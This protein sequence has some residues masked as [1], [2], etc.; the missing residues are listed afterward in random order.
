MGYFKKLEAEI[1][2][3]P[4]G[5]TY[6]HGQGFRAA[7]FGLIPLIGD[8]AYNLIDARMGTVTGV[9]VGPAEELCINIK[10][11]DGEEKEAVHLNFYRFWTKEK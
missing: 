4:E 2:D 9:Y 3:V 7:W 1:L 11:D 6:R 8:R 10:F 5:T